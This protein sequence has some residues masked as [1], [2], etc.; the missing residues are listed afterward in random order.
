MD[1][2]ASSGIALG[3]L[4]TGSVE[5]RADGLFHEW[6]IMN[7]RPWGAGPEARLGLDASYFGL[8]VE[9]GDERRSVI[10]AR[11]VDE[12]TLNDPY[13]M[14]WL[15]HPRAIAA[16][17][18]VP[19]TTLRYDLGRFPLD[20]S[21]EAWSP[22]IPLDAKHSGLPVAFFTFTLRNRGKAPAR[23]GLFQALRNLVGYTQPMLPSMIERR[24]VGRCDALVFTREGLPTEEDAFGSMALGVLGPGRSSHAV[25]TRNVRDVWDLLRAD[26]RLEDAD[27][28]SFGG[29][30]G[31]MGASRRGQLR[32]G[33]PYGVLARTLTLK[34]GQ[35]ET[36]T[37]VLAWHFPTM[38]ERP[39]PAKDKGP[40]PIGHRYSEWFDDAEAV[41][42]YSAR[43]HETLRAQTL[44]FR[45][46]YYDSSLPEW[47]LHAIGA[48]VTTLVKSSWW[49][50][51]GRF[52]IWEGLGCCGLQTT[53]I[54]H[55]GSFPIVQWFPEIQQSQMRLTRDTMERP[56]QVPHMMPGTFACCDVD[57]RGRIDLIPQFVLLVW[58][59]WRWTNDRAYAAEMWAAVEQALEH[60]DSFDTD[61]D[62]LPN[63]R[64]PDQTYDQFPLKGTSAFVGFLFA[65][66]L[67]AAAD[68][69]DALGHADIAQ[70]YR[71]RRGEA[72]AKLDAQ[73][74]TGQYYR[75]SHDEATGE[76]NDGV[77][78][79]QLNG[80][81]FCRQSAGEGLVSDARARSALRAVLAHCVGP[82]GYVANCAWPAGG[83]VTIGRHTAD[84]ANDP[85]SGVEYALAAHLA[86]LGLEKQALRVARDV[87]DR[88]ERAGLRFNHIECGGHYYRALSSWALY[89]AL[90]GFGL[91]APAGEITLA[92]DGARRCVVCTPAG[93]GQAV[94]DDGQLELT[95]RRG[96]L[97]LRSLRLTGVG[98]D[99]ARVTVAGKP[100]AV[101]VEPD[102]KTTRLT[103]A[104]TVT[105]RP[106]QTLR[107]RP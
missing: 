75:L 100:V 38:M 37:F 59:D 39:Y 99:T 83:A 18:R 93:W 91:D 72:L 7:N 77:M 65:A 46:A 76:D 78:A 12:R 24:R 36:V 49:D 81:W 48:Q 3:G 41:L 88:Y 29:D 43:R 61:G 21:L 51:R 34:P 20:V 11:P 23:V 8:H 64:G 67:G 103:L 32:Q 89:L 71:A 84:Q 107:V 80:D 82:T 97:S 92:A 104:R 2:L 15:E 25:H 87:W 57:H 60:F 44:E 85:W 102:A 63:N 40:M 35:T 27:Y 42:A 90:T 4:G 28:G 16:D 96:K 9:A 33:L 13:F 53:D 106:G 69:A 47:L 50:R 26:G 73:L 70:R 79:D 52:G 17:A 5:L 94:T 45:D 55:Y 54:T 98:L 105:L 14:P 66:S 86:L 6:Q 56:G 101:T 30:V 1:G 31:N 10:L 95:G 22:F 68:L 62:G 74:W 19:T 58:R